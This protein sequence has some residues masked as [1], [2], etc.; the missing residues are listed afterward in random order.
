MAREDHDPQ[1][2]R[3]TRPMR[4]DHP[5]T[6]RLSPDDAQ[7]DPLNP[8]WRSTR[9]TGRGRRSGSVPFSRQEL[10]LWLQYGGWRFLLAAVAILAVAGTLYVLS[11]P[12]PTPLPQ[13]T[14]E[15]AALP[16]LVATLPALATAT[17]AATTPV[18]TSAP[19]VATGQQLRVTGTDAQGLFLRA[20]PNTDPSNPPL[21]TLPEG[22]IVTVIGEPTTAAGRTWLRIRDESGS[23]GWAASDFLKPAQ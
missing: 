12:G 17:P 3:V 6:D 7:V 10:A 16:E 13:A 20:E 14:E 15:E 19:Q 1:N 23:E 2:P 22:A 4:R 21:K 9:S 5:S 8:G 11:Q 18:S